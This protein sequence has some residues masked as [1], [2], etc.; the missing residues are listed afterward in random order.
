MHRDWFL[1]VWHVWLNLLVSNMIQE[2]YGNNILKILTPCSEIIWGIQNFF[3]N[4]HQHITLAWESWI[5]V[6]R[7]EQK[8]SDL[9]TLKQLSKNMFWCSNHFY[10]RHDW[11]LSKKI[12][13]PFVVPGIINIKSL[14]QSIT[15][16]HWWIL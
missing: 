4:T 3:R 11:V 13:P 5:T 8:L 7:K 16:I 6:H 15:H 2:T 1:M 12:R 9:D 10:R 14:S